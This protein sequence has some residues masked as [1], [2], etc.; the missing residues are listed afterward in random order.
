MDPQSTH[1]YHFTPPDAGTFWYHSHYLSHEQVAR[2]LMGPLIVEEAT[3]PDV[4][5]D[6]TAVLADWRLD[7]TEQMT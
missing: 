6:I 3:P 4:D 5:H 7:E 1:A 2:G